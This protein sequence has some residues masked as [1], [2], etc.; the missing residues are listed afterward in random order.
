MFEGKKFD[1]IGAFDDIMG[2]VDDVSA[3]DLVTEKYFLSVNAFSME[4]LPTMYQNLR[5]MVE[6][7]PKEQ[8]TQEV[9][10]IIDWLNEENEKINQ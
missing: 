6:N 10:G 7:M 4:R 1:E 5:R 2:G 3:V 8:L 9:Q